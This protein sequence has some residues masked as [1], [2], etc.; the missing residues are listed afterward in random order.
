[1]LNRWTLQL[2]NKL[3]SLKFLGYLDHDGYPVIVP[4]IQAQAAGSN[5]VVFSTGAFGDE[6]SRIKAGA[7]VA[8][9]GMTLDM[10]DV[11]MR[12]SFLGFAR[13][14]GIRCGT[15]VVDWVYNPMPPTPGR[16]YPPATI[17]AISH[18]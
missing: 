9:F 7:T 10:E 17:E 4:V 14:G 18:F 8:I 6:L 11:L 12:G 15:V 13:S 3:D 5:E 2:L 16:I 1:V